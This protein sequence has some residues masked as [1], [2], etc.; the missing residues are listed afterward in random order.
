MTNRRVGDPERFWQS[1]DRLAGLVG[2][3]GFLVVMGE[4]VGKVPDSLVLATLPPA[5]VVLGFLLARAAGWGRRWRRRRNSPDFP[6]GGDVFRGLGDPGDLEA[7]ER[8]PRESKEQE[9]VARIESPETRFVSIAGESGSGKSV[10]LQAV[11]ERL[12]ASGHPV[13]VLDF[14]RSVDEARSTLESA[15]EWLQGVEKVGDWE[16]AAGGKK[17]VVVL[18][19]FETCIDEISRICRTEGVRL[20]RARAELGG[21]DQ[22]VGQLYR[23]LDEAPGRHVCL[24]VVV[25]SDRYYDLRLLE[26]RAD[27]PDRAVEVPG[28]E[29]DS[30]LGSSGRHSGIA[31]FVERLKKL[32]IA[33]TAKVVGDLQEEDGTLLPVKA[34]LAGCLLESRARPREGGDLRAR[35]DEKLLRNASAQEL[36]RYYF[37]DVVRG[38]PSPDVTKEVLFLLSK[39]GRVAK[40]L[41]IETL[42]SMTYRTKPE[43][44]QAIEHLLQK[45]EGRRGIVREAHGGYR[46]R[47]DYLAH[48]FRELSGRLLEP[49]RRDNLT[50]AYE[51]QERRGADL[52]WPADER[53][54][55]AKRFARLAKT[56]LLV[57][58]SYRLLGYELFPAWVHPVGNPSGP[59]DLYYLP[60]VLA[61]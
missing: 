21:R 59:M 32:Q 1:T 22:L 33:R 18:D 10:L 20:S 51:E 45:D 14:G 52:E 31:A 57:F 55:R 24:V 49:V 26:G 7:D 4:L 44:E 53:V 48:A 50:A 36:I 41:A 27:P 35:I 5:V 25:R 40:S 19:Q 60:L 61:Q 28:L 3:A 15:L 8:F 11:R 54:G 37:E 13:E 42:M 29:S 39:E 43:I 16:W 38:A 2:I 56:F 47:H 23:L 6:G 46:L 58:F 30:E 9:L 34:Q 12:A 17:A